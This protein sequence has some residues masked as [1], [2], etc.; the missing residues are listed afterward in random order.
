MKVPSTVD[1]KSDKKGMWSKATPGGAKP[2][3]PMPDRTT[4]PKVNSPEVTSTTL[5]SSSSTPPKELPKQ[6]ADALREKKL[7][8]L[9]NEMNVMKIEE[10]TAL[11]A[12][13]DAEDQKRREASKPVPLNPSRVSASDGDTLQKPPVT[14]S[15]LINK[16]NND[17]SLVETRTRNTDRTISE[18]KPEGV[19]RRFSSSTGGGLS[20]SYS[21]PNI[22]QLGQDEEEEENDNRIGNLDRRQ[23]INPPRFD[24]TLKPSSTSAHFK[25]RNFAPVYGLTIAGNT[26]LK[27]LGNT[28]FMNAVI[29]CLSSTFEL[30]SY[31]NEMKHMQDMNRNSRFG[32]RGELT[33]EL[34]ELIKQMWSG[35]FKNLTP[36]DLKDAVSKHMPVFVGCEQQDAHEFLTMLLEKLHND[37]NRCVENGPITIPSNLST[38]LAVKKFWTAHTSKNSSIISQLF[39]GLLLSTL[40]CSVCHTKSDSFEVFTCLSLPIPNGNRIQL[41]DC[42]KLFC[43]PELMTGDAAWDCPTC[44]CKRDSV[45]RIQL[46]YLP[47]VMIIHLKRFVIYAH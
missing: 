25:H 35:Q 13:K 27:N 26:G 41:M 31:F 16:N 21:S 9:D 14:Q 19:G 39:E 33:E 11:L 30:G 3:Q 42:F 44:K 17:T 34:A 46:T 45:K 6:S 32:T 8:Q 47:K 29:Q 18:S 12:L 38:P 10:L 4:K 7:L 5:R 15:S 20:R 22:A 36:R 40:E 1:L 37:L 23:S 43:E 2:V 24:R 28:C